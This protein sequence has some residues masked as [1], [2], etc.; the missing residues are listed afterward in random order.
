MVTTII[1]FI[2]NNKSTI[3]LA[4]GGLGRTFFALKNGGGLVGVWNSL[5]YGKS[6]K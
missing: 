3:A 1:D 5:V 6:T 4:I 2:L